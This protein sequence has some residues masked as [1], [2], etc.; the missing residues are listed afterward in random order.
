MTR[1]YRPLLEPLNL[2]Y[3]QYVLMIA[4][5]EEDEITLGELGAKVHFDSGTV[6]PPVK[7]LEQKGWLKRL[8]ADH[9]ER[10]KIIVLTEEGRALEADAAHITDALMC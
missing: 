3:P 5:W 8:P 9:D 2:T 10:K 7:R 1:L 4:L 6:T